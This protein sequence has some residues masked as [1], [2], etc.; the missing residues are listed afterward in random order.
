MLR[1]VE[2]ENGFI[3]GLPASDPRITVFKGVPFAAPPVYE[4]RWRAP[5]PCSDWEGTYNA[6]EF[7]P[8]PVQDRPGVGDDLYCR[9]WHVDPDIEMDEDSCI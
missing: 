5:V 8:I 4:N 1:I 9:E 6:Y 3:R 2:T 7:K